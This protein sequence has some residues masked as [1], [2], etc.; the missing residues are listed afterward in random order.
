MQESWAILPALPS[1]KTMTEMKGRAES[2]YCAPIHVDRENLA[3]LVT[4][5]IMA[6]RK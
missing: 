4:K 1:P 3:A 2:D 5:F 6:A